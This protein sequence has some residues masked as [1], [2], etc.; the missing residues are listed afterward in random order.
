MSATTVDLLTVGDLRRETGEPD[1]RIKY[2][3]QSYAI[4]PVGRIGNL[5][6]WSRDQLPHIK[7]ALRRIA[8]NREVAHVA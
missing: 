8:R 1:H 3:L 6:V 5:R 4:E 2:A 7:S